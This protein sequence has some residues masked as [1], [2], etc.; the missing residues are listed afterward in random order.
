MNVTNHQMGRR[1]FL[2]MASRAAGGAA[3]LGFAGACSGGSE[4]SGGGG[5]DV[6]Q[7]EVAVAHLK[8]IV[9]AAPFH[10]AAALGYYKEAN[11]ELEPVSFPGGTETIRGMATGMDFGMP[12]T[13]PGL[14]AVQKGQ[15]D[16]RLIAGAFN[17]PAVVFLV[18]ADS[19]IREISDLAN[20]KIA[21]SQPGSITT[22]FANRITKEQ[23]LEPGKN[24]Q[25]LNVGGPP[26]AWTAAKQGV[27]DVAWSNPP[28]SDKL[29]ADG[30]ARI[31]FETSDFVDHWPDV[32]YWTTQPF[33]DESGDVLKRWLKAQEQAMETIKSD[34]DKAAE[35]YAKAVELDQEVAKTSLQDAADAF[36]LSIDMA[37][38]EENLKAGGEMGQ[39]DP[40]DFDLN[41]IV[42]E[43]FASVK[44]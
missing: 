39:L 4:G 5:E 43:E 31:L 15:Q 33:I 42:S 18:P 35:I 1:G 34:V 14:I 8:A 3:M 38:V 25:I 2:V 41:K 44:S 23:G 7:G 30:E 28:L 32:S 22:Y 26:D 11:L 21:V 29:V 10:I 19:K 16:L 9:G 27:A 17:K 40:K 13:L 6:Y 37:G 20:K 36:D 24:V 12:A